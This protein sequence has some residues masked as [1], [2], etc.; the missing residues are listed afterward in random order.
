MSPTQARQNAA[1]TRA[2]DSE[3]RSVESTGVRGLRAGLR[4]GYRRLLWWSRHRAL[5]SQG[6]A[7]AG[8]AAGTAAIGAFSILLPSGWC[9]PSMVVLPILVGSF[10]LGIRSQL[11][12]LLVVGGVFVAADLWGTPHDVIAGSALVVAV[13]ALLAIVMSRMR[14]R[15][16]VQGTRG[17]SMLFD[18]HERLLAQ[19]RI[20]A[21]PPGWHVELALRSAGGQ[22]FAGD[23]L[24]AA[25]SDSERLLELGLV[26]VSG[27]GLQAG[28]RSLQ[29]S[30]AFGGLLGS[31]PY[32]RFLPAANQYLLR[33]GWDEGFATAVHIV[34]DVESGA[35]ELFSAGHPPIAQLTASTGRWDLVEAEG[36][37]L[38]IIDDCDYVGR[39]GRLA[40]GDALLLFTDGLV[41]LPGRD[42]S[43]GLDRLLGAA[44]SLV[45]R[46]FPNGAE[47][48]VDAVARDVNDD[49]ALVVV[50]RD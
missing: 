16:G 7:L 8:L 5:P 22:S 11:V 2:D 42:L 15:L 10:L 12:L 33:Q 4:R 29:L 6:F 49:R 28:T 21:L 17:E 39:H 13:A 44:E 14:R 36:P 19:G 30:G 43:V 50:W 41:E 34:V 32:R 35:Y 20:P 40:P 9:P 46:G 1:L 3:T 27:K 37:M 45:T 48:V 31:I 24:I 38:G 23:F 47:R 26:D 25:T 18:L